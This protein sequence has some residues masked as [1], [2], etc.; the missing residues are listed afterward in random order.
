MRYEVLSG[1]ST[2]TAAETVKTLEQK[3]N[4]A[5]I[6]GALV[7]G[8]VSVVFGRAPG[9]WAKYA[10]EAFQTVMFVDKT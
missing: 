8:G 4:D 10:H 2:R 9:F 5:I 6:A 3:V 7:T 1:G